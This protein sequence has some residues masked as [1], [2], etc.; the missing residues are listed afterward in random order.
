MLA[1]TPPPYIIIGM[2]RS[3]TTALTKVLEKAGIFMGV[4]KDHN[5]EAMHFLSLN[6]QAL[7]AEGADWLNPAIPR[8]ENWSVPD[9]RD[10]YYEHFKAS[11]KA[12]QWKLRFNPQPWGWKDPRN[13]FTL[14]RWLEVFPK[15]R[16]IHLWRDGK[17][18]AL[19]L[20]KRNQQAHEV[21]DE[22]LDDLNFNYSL[23]ELYV[24]QAERY[25]KKMGNRFLHIRYSDL[26]ARNTAAINDLE[27]FTSRRLFGIIDQYFY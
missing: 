22:R 7:W 19:S 3:G 15:A 1:K 2:H 16:V 27:K 9:V 12:A 24:N 17:E 5:L 25:R 20:Q 10:L 13:T 8:P 14:P 18:V 6:Q 11:T 4:I 23:W 21:H 26:L